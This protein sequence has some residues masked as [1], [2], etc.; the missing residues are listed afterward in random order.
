MTQDC[1]VT[2]SPC[3]F[4]CMPTH[5]SIGHAQSRHSACRWVSGRRVRLSARSGSQAA[6]M[7]KPKQR[8]SAPMERNLEPCS[9]EVLSRAGQHTK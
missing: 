9:R 4:E 3:A 6:T 5:A 7:K 1:T 8:S 2:T